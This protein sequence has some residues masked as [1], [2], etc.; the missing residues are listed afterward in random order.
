MRA[1]D[2]ATV[3]VWLESAGEVLASRQDDLTSLDAAIG[4]GDHGINM[5]RGFGALPAIFAEHTAAPPGSVLKSAG[6]AILSN[7]G[8]ASGALWGVFFRAASKVLGDQPEVAPEQLVAALRAGLDSI[9][10]LGA[11]APGD[12]T[13]VDALTPAV[14][15][16]E[17]ASPPGGEAFAAAAEA[18]LLGA[19][20]TVPLQ[21]RKGRASYLG[22]RSIGH[23]DPGAASAAI[24]IRAL[25]DTVG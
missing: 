18:S 8:G 25:A 3:I 13:M 12:K 21:A 11:S 7:V 19:A 5:S 20:S 16:L 6:K 15:C 24:V 10:A 1:L 4:D 2:G 9:K 14:E 22:E 23:E 17:S